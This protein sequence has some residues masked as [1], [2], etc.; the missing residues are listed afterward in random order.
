MLNIIIVLI[1]SYIIFLLLTAVSAILINYFYNKEIN[2]IQII[3]I[4]NAGLGVSLMI[5]FMAMMVVL[6]LKVVAEQ[7]TIYLFFIFI[8]SYFLTV[9]AS[10]Y[11][12]I[13]FKAKESVN[14]NE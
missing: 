12:H 6:Q 10:L 5:S 7:K 11:S 4:S 8:S 1:C 13:V 9:A 14:N 3:Q 2:A